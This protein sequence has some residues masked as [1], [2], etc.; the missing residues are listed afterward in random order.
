MN[1]AKTVTVDRVVLINDVANMIHIPKIN[2]FGEDDL[3][4]HG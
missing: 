2:R 4:H 3:F 1:N